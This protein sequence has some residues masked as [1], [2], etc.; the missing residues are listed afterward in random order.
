MTTAL[1]TGG[2]MEAKPAPPMVILNAVGG[3]CSTTPKR[4]PWMII[5]H[6]WFTSAP[7]TM[8]GRKI[9]PTLV[10]A[11]LPME[12]SAPSRPLASPG[13]ILGNG[14]H[15]IYMQITQI[16]VTTGTARLYLRTFLLGKPFTRSKIHWDQVLR[17][18]ELC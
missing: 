3:T 2:G 8:A 18:V 10:T 14:L 15:R 16:L 4:L 12:V 9:P 7:A 13:I 1:S 5:T 11:S 17:R 6:P